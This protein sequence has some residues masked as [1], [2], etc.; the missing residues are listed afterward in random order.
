MYEETKRTFVITQMH[1]FQTRTL[2]LLNL[3]PN[4]V[5]Y[6]KNI[7]I[8]SKGYCFFPLNCSGLTRQMGYTK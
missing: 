4:K 8:V 5:K 7:N 3:L 2:V 1:Y 6:K